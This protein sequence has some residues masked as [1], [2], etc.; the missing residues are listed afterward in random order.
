VIF[1][2]AFEE[3]WHDSEETGR[4]VA[5]KALMQNKAKEFLK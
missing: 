5:G 4:V 1:L 2:V 3:N